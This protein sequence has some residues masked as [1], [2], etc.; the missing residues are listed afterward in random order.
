[1]SREVTELLKKALELPVTDR[2]ELAGSLI[3]SLDHAKDE[4]VENAWNAEIA[5]RMEDLDSGR[6]KPVS[7]NEFRRRLDSALE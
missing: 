6:V 2:A 4:S 3:E 7:L 1:M 5:R